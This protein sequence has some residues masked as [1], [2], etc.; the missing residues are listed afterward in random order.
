MPIFLLIIGLYLLANLWLLARLFFAL[1]GAGI[2]RIVACLLVL[3]AFCAYPM[4]RTIEG[5]AWPVKLLATVGS[6]WVAL[7]LHSIV[8][9]FAVDIFRLLNRLFNWLPQL[10]GGAPVVRYA[11]CAAIAA[12]A[13]LIS[14]IG[15]INTAYPVVREIELTV[16][17]Q[18]GS[19]GQKERTLTVAALS[20]IHLGRVVSAAYFSRLIEMIE[21]RNPDLV[22][23]VGDILDDYP[24]LDEP[25][26]TEALRRLHP[27]LGIWGILGNHEYIA[28]DADKSM[29]ILERSGIRMLRDQW[30]APENEVL[31]VGR[32]DLSIS[33]FTGKERTGLPGILGT[34]PEAARRLPLILLD[35][36]PFHLEEAEAAGAALQL[37]GHTHDGQLFPVNFVVAAIYE[38]AYGHS[39]RGTTHYWV[40]S[41]AGTWGPP[42]RTT[43]R[44][45]ILLIKIKF[46]S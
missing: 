11:T 33:R 26:M 3:V 12:G 1:H 24:G 42:V 25:A 5:N 8:I 40:S 46:T 9:L 44:P 28:G 17:S 29:Q 36:Q 45:E 13:L 14:G 18:S 6:L 21:P 30:A 41:G 20:D 4:A 38:N 10:N 39:Q 35:H 32:D 43:G 16:P 2:F 22:L 31:L 15:W 23:F 37:S 19:G 7:A 34:V 27:R